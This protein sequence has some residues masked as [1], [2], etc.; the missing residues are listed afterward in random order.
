MYQVD[1][2]ELARNQI[3]ATYKNE[4]LIKKYRD[5]IGHIGDRF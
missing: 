3:L 1:I 4:K 5:D 2:N